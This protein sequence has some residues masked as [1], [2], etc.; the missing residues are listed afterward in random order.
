M[1]R[2]QVRSDMTA[3]GRVNIMVLPRLRHA[4]DTGRPRRDAGLVGLIGDYGILRG[5]LLIQRLWLNACNKRKDSGTPPTRELNPEPRT[6]P[7]IDRN[8][9]SRRSIGV[10]L[11][12]GLRSVILL[13]FKGKLPSIHPKAKTHLTA[14]VFERLLVVGVGTEDHWQRT[15]VVL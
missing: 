1:I 8:L 9:V 3:I 15:A 7:L 2:R 10:R 12:L 14:H 13:Q 11:L 4:R 5:D 6:T